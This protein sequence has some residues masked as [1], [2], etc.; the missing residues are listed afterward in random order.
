MTAVAT[1]LPSSQD[2]KAHVLQ[3][4]FQDVHQFERDNYSHRRFSYDGVD[5]SQQFDLRKHVLYLDW[6]I[7]RSQE[8][9]R[10][11]TILEDDESRRLLIDL[12]RY[13]LSGHLHV[14]INAHVE[15]LK[16]ESQRLAATFVGTPSTVKATGMFGPLMH[17]DQEWNGERYVV[18]ST[19]GGLNY[20]L[21]FRQY[22]FERDGIRIAPETGDHV[23]DGGACMGDSMVIFSK[24]VGPT[25]KVYAF[26]PLQN[27][28]DVCRFNA[29]QQPFANMVLFGA[30]LSDRKVDAPPVRMAEISPG[31]RVDGAPVPLCRIDDLASDGRVER[32][33]FIK[34]DIEGSEMAALRGALA[35][36]RSYRP[37]LAI[38]IY[39]K[40]DDLFEICNFLHDQQLG[41]RFFID[42]YAIYDEETVLYGIP[43]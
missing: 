4:F 6:F 7:H 31:F 23:I 39:H 30:G 15:Q 24:A 14:R 2:F 40:P 16:G 3:R 41:Y 38:S 37:K 42:H 20:L 8:L 43:R 5:R 11:Y 19:S 22:F 9:Y 26:D 33:D 27:H 10:T 1:L 25:G 12:I 35:S 17:F 34:M 36:I 18:D 13:R 21:V 29:E 32:I 28:L